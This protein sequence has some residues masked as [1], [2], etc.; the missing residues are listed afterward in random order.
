MTKEEK[1]DYA[2]RRI[3]SVHEKLKLV[4]IEDPDF[5]DIAVDDGEI[6]EGKVE[7]EKSCDDAA[8]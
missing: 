2:S 3:S 7:E 8:Q 4:D 1:F 6:K 5:N